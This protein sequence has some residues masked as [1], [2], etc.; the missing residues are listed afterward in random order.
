MVLL[1]PL[2][3]AYRIL[4]RFVC[5]TL[6]IP[7]RDPTG[8]NFF[9]AMLTAICSSSDIDLKQISEKASIE[10]DVLVSY[11]MQHR[12]PMDDEQV[13]ILMAVRPFFDET[14]WCR[15]VLEYVE[16]DAKRQ[17]LRLALGAAM[18][19]NAAVWLLSMTNGLRP[20]GIDLGTE[21][22]KIVLRR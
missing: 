16:K 20:K 7:Y 17:I 1:M 14:R 18:H 21:M 2:L 3:L 6:R 11:C 15:M 5:Q 4:G 9:S 22:M 19:A 10:M 12:E 13:R 8:S